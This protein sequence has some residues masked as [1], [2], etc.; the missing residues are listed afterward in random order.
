MFRRCLFFGCS[1]HILA[2][3][4][5]RKESG[6]VPEFGDVQSDRSKFEKLVPANRC[7][8]TAHAGW[9]RGGNGNESYRHSG[10][11]GWDDAVV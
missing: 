5:E 7:C 9:R 11:E 3:G 6:A 2:K 4:K 10:Q 8:K 1:E